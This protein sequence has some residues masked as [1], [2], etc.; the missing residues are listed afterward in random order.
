MLRPFGVGHRRVGYVEPR[1][2]SL[3]ALGQG[4]PLQV[5]AWLWAGF[6]AGSAAQASLC[7][8][9]GAQSHA[10]ELSLPR[11]RRLLEKRVG[12]PRGPG[13]L[14]AIGEGSCRGQLFFHVLC[15]LFLVPSGG[16]LETPAPLLYPY[17]RTRVLQ[18]AGRLPRRR[19]YM[20]HVTVGGSQTCVFSVVR[21]VWRVGYRWVSLLGTGLESCMTLSATKRSLALLFCGVWGS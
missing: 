3:S 11:G 20:C 18:A 17:I 14:A 7:M 10:A 5:C 15:H 16:T 2:V 21:A 13:L 1:P 12:H 4:A 19:E 8:W 6:L 9:G